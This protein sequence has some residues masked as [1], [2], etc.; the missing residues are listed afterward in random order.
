MIISLNNII[1]KKFTL[2]F[3]AAFIALSLNTYAQ[4]NV[5]DDVIAMSPAH[6]SLKLALETANLDDDLQ[7]PMMTFTVFAPTNQA[8]DDA[9]TA[10][11]LADINALL[12]LPNLAD[13]LLYHVLDSEV[14][15]MN[16]SNGLIAAP[17]NTSNTLKFTVDGS[18][19]FV[20]Q[21]PISGVDLTTDNGVVHVLDAIVLPNQTVTDIALGSPAH[22]SLV[23]AVVEARLLPALT[24]PFATYTVFAPTNQAFDDAVTAL[25]LADINALLA[26]PN[27]ADILLY[28]VLDSE[29]PSMNVTNG[30]I[31][32][33]LNTANTIKFTV[34][35][36]NVYAN[37]SPISGVDLS[38]TNGVVHVLDQV[39]LPNSTVADVAIGSPAHTSLVAAVV[40]ARLLPALTNPFTQLTVF[41][42][43]DQAFTDLAAAL[44]T[45]LNGVLAHPQLEDILLYHV[46]AGAALSGDLSDGPLATLNGQSV[47]V[48]LSSGVMINTAAVTTPNLAVDNGVVHVI[49][50]VLVPSLAS[51]Q[52][53]QALN[54]NVYPNPATDFIS[55]DGLGTVFEEVLI[56]D[57]NGRVL[58]QTSEVTNS[59]DV[60]SLENGTYII[61]LSSNDQMT[62][63]K[64]SIN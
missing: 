29:V 38:A 64:L 32:T 40:E 53:E 28:H 7:N 57:L 48:D 11:G 20:N 10:L 51:L 44:S 49:N 41:A 42:P 27:L 33:P 62:T 1:M 26:L 12:A 47:T 8:F 43:T 13:I 31:A 54:F 52:E 36:T 17:M 16:V 3:S 22:T 4:T 6:T 23:A 45:D 18:N 19:V 25:G 2:G 35:G 30:L 55:I 14:P 60:N 9:V 21:A 34:D 59:I 58:I 46:V 63:K 56:M 24:D 61:G 37:Q 50:A 39:I 15:S 5:F